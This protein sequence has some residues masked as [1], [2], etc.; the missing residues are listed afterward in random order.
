MAGR[1]GGVLANISSSLVS[2]LIDQSAHHL[3]LRGSSPF[4]PPSVTNARLQEVVPK[5]ERDEKNARGEMIV[6]VDAVR[7]CLTTLS[8]PS[9][10]L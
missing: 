2:I 8:A 3:D 4:D 9:L 1:P 5:E 6:F 7:H 10:L